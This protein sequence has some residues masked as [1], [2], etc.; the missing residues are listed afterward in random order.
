MEHYSRL[1]F[2]YNQLLWSVYGTE[3]YYK[4]QKIVENFGHICDQTRLRYIKVRIDEVV[5]VC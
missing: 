3:L 5:F 4:S 2:S 1:F